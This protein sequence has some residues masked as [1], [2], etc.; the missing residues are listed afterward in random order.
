MLDNKHTLKVIKNNLNGSCTKS[1]LY[2]YNHSIPLSPRFQDAQYVRASTTHYRGNPSGAGLN[3]SANVEVNSSEYLAL[4]YFHLIS[5][6]Q[7]VK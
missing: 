2:T 6:F 5:I 1:T 3:F 4:T 7:N